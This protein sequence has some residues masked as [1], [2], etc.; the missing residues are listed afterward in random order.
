[1]QRRRVLARIGTL[2]VGGLLGARPARAAR[3]DRWTVLEC[4]VAGTG[5]AGLPS[6]YER[7]LRPGMRLACRRELDNAVDPLAIRIAAPDGRKLGYVPR[8]QNEALA[9]LMD[10]GWRAEAEVLTVQRIET[11]LRV[12]VRVA[13]LPPAEASG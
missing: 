7:R 1:M 4:H 6:D 12:D 10:G 3:R 8:A 2:L 5:Y 9:R 11:W 13:L